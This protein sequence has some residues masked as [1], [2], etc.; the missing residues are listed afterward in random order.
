MSVS[1]IIPEEVIKFDIIQCEHTSTLL[2]WVLAKNFNK[3]K[4]IMIN[5]YYCKVKPR[6]RAKTKF[7]FILY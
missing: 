3:N 6:I 2:H 5:Q 7:Y 1:L 4:K